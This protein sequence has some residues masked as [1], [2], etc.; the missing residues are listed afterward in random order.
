VIDL[1]P[2][3]KP[4]AIPPYQFSLPELAEL[5]S[6]L[7]EMLEL[8]FI[9]PSISPWATP[10]LFKKK[11]DGSLRL[12]ID[13]RGLNRATVKNRYQIPRMDDLLDRIQGARLFSKIDLR[14]G[15]H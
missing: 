11:K 7:D 4:I 12:C 13:Y 10:V 1:S 14:S 3:A 6:Q 9:R 5:K 2:D 8:G 15:Y